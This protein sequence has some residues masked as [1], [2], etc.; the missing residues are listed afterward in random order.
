ME[1]YRERVIDHYPLWRREGFT[2]KPYS[3]VYEGETIMDEDWQTASQLMMQTLLPGEGVKA[4]YLILHK[5][6]DCNY[7]VVSQWADHNMLRMLAYRSEKK[8]PQNY[9]DVT[10]SGLS[11][12]VWDMQIHCHERN[13]YVQHI[14]RDPENT[15]LIAYYE[16][17]YR[18]GSPRA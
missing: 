11:V 16:D 10:A 2:I 1:R 8:E 7:L 17:L 18:N 12:C 14:L 3:V 13:A 4:A 5:G 6:K 9:R 15:N